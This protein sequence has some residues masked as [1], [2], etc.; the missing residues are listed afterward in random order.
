[1]HQVSLYDILADPVKRETLIFSVGVVGGAFGLAYLRGLQHD[2]ATQTAKRSALE[3]ALEEQYR[4]VQELDEELAFRTVLAQTL[5][6]PD[7]LLAVAFQGTGSQDQ[8]AEYRVQASKLAG[9]TL[10]F[11]RLCGKVQGK[12]DEFSLHLQQG[13]RQLDVARQAYA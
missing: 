13:Y 4:S 8:L 2:W 11:H 10:W 5:N 1:M 7:Q 6:Q 9:G 12:L 3:I